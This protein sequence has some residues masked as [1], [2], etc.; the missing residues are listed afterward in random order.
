MSKSKKKVPA[1]PDFAS[2]EKE[3]AFWD[4]HD[5][6]EFDDGMAEDII[7]SLNPKPKRPVTLRL[8]EDLIT[9]LKKAANKHGVRYQTL[10][11]ELLRRSMRAYL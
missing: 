4:K 3:L 2:E 7:L 11:R 10:A 8:D 6:R 1:L 9:A 5:I